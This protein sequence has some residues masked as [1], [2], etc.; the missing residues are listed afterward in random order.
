MDLSSATCSGESEHYYMELAMEK[1]IMH[2][3][4]V[5]FLLHISFTLH[6]TLLSTQQAKCQRHR[7]SLLV[8][9]LDISDDVPQYQA[10]VLA[11]VNYIMSSCANLDARLKLRS[12]LNG[13][14]GY[15]LE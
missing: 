12:E 6:I 13:E 11:F 14:C 4:I 8:H 3:H 5:H 15:G 7:Y 9:E 2:G 1:R 10:A